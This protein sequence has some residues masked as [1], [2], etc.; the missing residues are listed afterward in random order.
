MPEL[1]LHL[2]TGFNRLF[3]TAGNIAYVLL[4]LDT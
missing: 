2:I 4:F 1:H 3:V